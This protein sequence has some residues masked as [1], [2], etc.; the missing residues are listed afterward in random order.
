MDSQRPCEFAQAF[1]QQPCGIPMADARH[2]RGGGLS[3]HAR[4]NPRTTSRHPREFQTRCGLRFT[5]IYGDSGNDSLYGTAAI[6]RLSTM[7][8]IYS[9]PMVLEP[10]QH[11]ILGGILGS[12]T[13]PK[14]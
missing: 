9:E 7:S 11:F 1:E 6:A 3:Q 12:R 10:V 2:Q 5:P 14:N 8:G 13:V 4:G